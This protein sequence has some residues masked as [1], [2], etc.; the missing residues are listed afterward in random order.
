MSSLR[1]ID[2]QIVAD[3]VDFVRGT[4]YVLDF[5]DNT[6]SAF[7]ASELNVDIDDPRYSDM[8]GSKGKRLRRYLQLVDNEAAKHALTALWDHRTAFLARTGSSDSVPNA[9]GRY[10]TVMTRLKGDLEQLKLPEPPKPA[11]DV[12]RLDELKAELLALSSVTPQERGYRFER[13]LHSLFAANHLRPR[14]PFRNRG[15]QIDGSFIL[16]ADTYL[17]E[18]KWVQQPV[19]IA[20][21]FAFEG[22]LLD[23]AAWARGLFVSW[24]GFS[25][26]GLYRF[27]RGKRTVCMSGQDLY[28]LLDRRLLL[29]DVIDRKAR[30]AVETGL[31]FTAL[32]DLF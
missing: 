26:D 4:G 21:L 25:D 29:D 17:V 14:E 16:G 15:E 19:G 2:L 9:E 28:D 27:G 23:K 31:P 5:G 13:F 11:F 12:A 3:L 18:A 22:K 7:F 1:T 30:R 6:F 32:R 8:G 24:S 20:E 10:C